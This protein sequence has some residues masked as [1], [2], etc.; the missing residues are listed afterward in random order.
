MQNSPQRLLHSRHRFVE[1]RVRDEHAPHGRLRAIERCRSGLG[2]CVKRLG[3]RRR[4]RVNRLTELLHRARRLLTRLRDRRTL[5]D[6]LLD[7]LLQLRQRQLRRRHASRERGLAGFR[8][9]SNSDSIRPD[10][11]TQMRFA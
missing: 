2:K 6:G 3:R 5:D 1:R 4:V 10:A 8:R 9:G 7:E 11:G